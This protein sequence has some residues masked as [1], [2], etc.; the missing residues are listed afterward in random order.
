MGS[1]FEPTSRSRHAFDEIEVEKFIKPA[2]ALAKKL[3]ISLMEVL[4][5]LKFQKRR[6][7]VYVNNGNIFDEQMMGF[8]EMLKEFVQKIDFIITKVDEKF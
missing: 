1:L 3:N 8:G 7:K 2:N 5:P 6:N 4:E